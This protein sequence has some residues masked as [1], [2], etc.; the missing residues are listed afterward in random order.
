MGNHGNKGFLMELVV[1][2]LYMAQVSFF[3][4]FKEK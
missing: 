3:V 2:S 1:Y 4:A